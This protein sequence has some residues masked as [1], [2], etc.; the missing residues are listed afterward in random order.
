MSDTEWA[1]IPRASREVPFGYIV[2]PQ[3]EKWFLPVPLELDN[4]ELAKEHVR[5]Y[6]Y[7]EVADWLAAT[8]GRSISYV[9][10][11]KRIESEALRRYKRG[12]A[13]KWAAA[14]EKKREEADRLAKEYLGAKRDRSP[15]LSFDFGQDM[16]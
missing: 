16:G 8:T 4:L 7:R 3:N 9:G 1:P 12:V 10:L 6:S 15:Q 13:L 11:K 5:K 2:D 14:A